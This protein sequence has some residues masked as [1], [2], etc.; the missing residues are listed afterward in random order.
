VDEFVWDDRSLQRSHDVTERDLT[1]VARQLVAAMR[2]A[3]AANDAYASQAAQ[4]LVEV[5][6][7]DLLRGSDL[8]ALHRPLPVASG[9]LDDGVSPI[10]AAHGQ[11]HES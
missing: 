11:P 10:V 9:K 6:F 3:D 8:S 2:P 5:G 7:G 1:R 4:Q